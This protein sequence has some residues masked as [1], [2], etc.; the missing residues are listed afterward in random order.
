MRPVAG[1][2]RQPGKEAVAGSQ[3]GSQQADDLAGRRMRVNN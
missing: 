2:Q 1:A 3:V